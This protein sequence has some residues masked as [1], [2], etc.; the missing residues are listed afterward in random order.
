MHLPCVDGN[1]EG[2]T[3][4]AVLGKTHDGKNAG[5]ASLAARTRADIEVAKLQSKHTSLAFLDCSK[6]Y[7]R[8]GHKLAGGRA[9]GTRLRPRVANMVFDMSKG[10]RHIKAHGAV[11]HELVAGCAFAQ[12]ILTAFMVT[13]KTECPEGEPRDYVDDI[14]LRVE[15]ATA[16]E[17][18]ARMH[19][20]LES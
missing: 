2:T 19:A 4:A 1:T 5:A 20:R 11:A 6:C 10:D 7:E 9:V 12:D 3:I 8:E 18:A 15:G 13:I 16:A 17:C 14:T